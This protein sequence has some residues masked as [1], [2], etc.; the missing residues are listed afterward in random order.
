MTVNGCSGM[1]TSQSEF[2]LIGCIGSYGS[3]NGQFKNPSDVAIDFKNQLIFVVDT[4]NRRI[5]VFDESTLTFKYMFTTPFKPNAVTVHWDH[6]LIISFTR[7]SL[8]CKYDF[9]GNEIWRWGGVTTKNV[10]DSPT[11]VVVDYEGN[12]Y[13]CDWFKHRIVVF[14]PGG[15]LLKSIGSMGK[16]YGQFSFP[17][18]I[19]IDSAG[20]IIISDSGNNRIQ[21]LKSNGEFISSFGSIGNDKG[22]FQAPN[23]VFVDKSTGD[24]F[25]TEW[26]SHRISKFHPN[27]PFSG[28]TCIGSFGNHENSLKYP[29][30]IAF[31]YGSSRL[32]IVD[33]GNNRI[34]VY[35]VT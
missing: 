2:E 1:K 27:N 7:D 29:S 23:S 4:D 24:I 35:R 32:F 33:T 21:I 19:D 5:Q 8:I 14:S 31:C 6:T 17:R 13:V 25:L 12:I 18:D 3:Q 10:M 28:S 15:E 11:G 20:N 22:E 30:G 26:D 34:K 16:E 9:N